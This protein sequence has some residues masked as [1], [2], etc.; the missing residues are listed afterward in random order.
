MPI[1]VQLL[2]VDF[3]SVKYWRF[4]TTTIHVFPHTHLIMLTL[5][6][7]RNYLTYDLGYAFR[8]DGHLLETSGLTLQRRK[9]PISYWHD[10][11]TNNMSTRKCHRDCLNSWQIHFSKQIYNTFNFLALFYISFH[12][13]TSD[14][15]CFFLSQV[16]GSWTVKL[17]MQ[18]HHGL[19]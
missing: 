4:L 10:S 13:I 12:F 6:S 11:I 5:F 16:K 14:K 2:S 3:H 7:L 19:C 1:F 9:N 8:W 18:I 15:L 17:T